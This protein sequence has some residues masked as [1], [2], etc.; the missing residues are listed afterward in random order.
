MKETGPHSGDRNAKSPLRRIMDNLTP[1]PLNPDLVELKK[2]IVSGQHELFG[3][4][5]HDIEFEEY[6]GTRKREQFLRVRNFRDGFETSYLSRRDPVTG[7]VDLMFEAVAGYDPTK[8][9]D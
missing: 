5:T 3:E 7:E 6:P 4:I 9:R 8:P 1:K 2:K